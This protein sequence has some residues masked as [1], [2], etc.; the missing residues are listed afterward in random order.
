MIIVELTVD[1]DCG[2]D[3]TLSPRCDDDEEHRVRAE[4]KRQKEV[5]DCGAFSTRKSSH[6]KTIVPE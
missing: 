5:R 6:D 3:D 2:V 1:D 4:L